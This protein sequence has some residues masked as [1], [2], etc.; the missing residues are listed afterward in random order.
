M[1]KSDKY[2][3]ELAVKK[4]MQGACKKGCGPFGAIVVKDGKVIA[5]AYNE[6]I[7][8]NDPSAH[9][10]VLAIRRACKKLG[11]FQLEGCVIYS[12]CEPCPMCLG[13]IYWARP[14]R[15]VFACSKEDAK[16]AG[17][18]DHLIYCEINKAHSDKKIRFELVEL[19]NSKA[20]IEAWLKHDQKVKY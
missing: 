2:F 19:K 3:L 16:N 14:L 4:A 5:R 12:S 10:E 9:A 8:L 7:K 15:V 13:A 18:D 1:N 20:P 17:F 11:S 6:V